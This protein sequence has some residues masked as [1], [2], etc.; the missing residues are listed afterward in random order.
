MAPRAVII[1]PPGAGK[2]T[3]GELL[4]ERLGVPFV[5][6]DTAV[7]Q[8]AGKTISEL[9][10]VDGEETFR[11]LEQQT[12]AELLVEHTGVLALGGGAVLATATQ[13]RLRDYPVV[14]LGVGLAEGVRRTGMSVARPLLTGVNPRA[15][16][17][18]LLDARLP[19]YRAVSSFEVSTD[20]RTP[21]QV[22]TEIE[23]ELFARPCQDSDG[24]GAGE[25]RSE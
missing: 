21:E 6:S 7:E 4:A 2:S 18:E 23:S 11:E 5:D 12:I 19:T 15:M 16:Y 20:E 9:F 3:V 10:T 14:L 25:K 22:V 17:R 13:Q 8:R 24:A 1:G